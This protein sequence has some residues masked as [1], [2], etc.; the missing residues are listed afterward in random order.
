MPPKKNCDDYNQYYTD[1]FDND[2]NLITSRCFKGNE[3]YP[4]MKKYNINNFLNYKSKEYYYWINNNFKE[5]AFPPEDYDSS[6]YNPEKAFDDICGKDV[7]YSLKPQQ[8]FAA[9][10]LNTNVNNNGMLIYHGLGSGKTQTSIIIGEAFKFRDIEG[11]IIHG[12]TEQRVLIVVP[13]A[14]E[15]Q[16]YAEI[17]G[18][19]ENDEIKSAPGEVVIHGNRQYY[20]SKIFRE[21][22]LNK[23]TEIIKLEELLFNETDTIKKGIIKNNIKIVSNQ[24]ENLKETEN[25]KIIRSYNIMSHDTF[26]NRL[27]KIEDKQFIEQEGISWLKIPNG[28][29]IIDEIQN[30]ISA[31]GSSYRKLLYALKYHA[32][33][34]FRVV[35]LTGTP[36]YD[37]PYEFGSL[38]N[39][40]RPRV[41]F[42][43]GPKK[44][45]KIFL[46][47]NNRLINIDSFKKMCS[48]YVS[49]FKGGNPITYPYKKTV[50]MNHSMEEYQ[51]NVYKMAL[52][53]EVKKDMESIVKDT[54]FYTKFRE[55]SEEL[56]SGI[57]NNSNQFSNIVFPETPVVKKGEK[58]LEQNVAELY[59]ILENIYKRTI[60]NKEN[61]IIIEVRKYSSKFAK[62]AEM[63]IES[64]N[65]GEGGI[66]IFSNYVFYGVNP[67]ATIMKLL[68]YKPFPEKGKRG[69]YFVWN[70]EANEKNPKLVE[71]AK[72]A[73]NH[74]DNINGDLLKIMFG[75]RTVMEG[76]DFKNVNQIHILEPWWNDSRL[77]QV[78]ARGI[79]LCSHKDLSSEKR[80]VNVFIHLSTFGSSNK[81]FKL[82]IN[83]KQK[84]GTTLLRNVNSELKVENPD[85]PNSGKW[86]LSIAY[87]HA[88]YKQESLTELLSTNKKF[89]ASDIVPGS[90]K[91]IG[92]D[93]LHQAFGS[94]KDL[95]SISVQEYMFS[96]ATKKLDINRQ[97]EKV[98]KE[99][100]IDCNINK[101]GNVIRLNEFYEPYLP[102]K[103]VW[104][105]HYENYSTGEKYERIGVKSLYNERLQYNLLTLEDILN[106]TAKNFKEYKFKNML[107]DKIENFNKNLILSENINCSDLD[108]SFKFPKEIV[109]LTINKELIVYL[110][111]M[112]KEKILDFLYN[113]AINNETVKDKSLRTKIY[114]FLNKSVV[115][116]RDAAIQ[117]IVNS[118]IYG[119]E[120]TLWENFTLEELLLEVKQIQK[121]KRN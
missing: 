78:I 114:S 100:A 45:N 26:L 63:I 18:K 7:K 121:N 51:Y 113:V 27:F 97:F 94:H 77:Q 62:I 75:T 92:D 72:Q 118:G 119:D 34:K 96:R 41:I 117:I 84:D 112:G 79:R 98:I 53:K 85:E 48:G 14:L 37:K 43:D 87:S 3:V 31:T 38:I 5:Y 69:S 33:P 6:D 30:L 74:P 24:L 71:R 12:R 59:R 66:F 50:I 120:T 22:V 89:F 60:D 32:H 55:P 76:V 101:N 115:A 54:D 61:A 52:I 86:V 35:F 23:H 21:R 47:E 17:I 15:K 16:Y 39:L 73:F 93:D 67:L 36:I 9:R 99:V 80:I 68:E 111:N 65:R 57:F 104:K 28:L 4:E 83:E 82:K 81:L 91:R 56:N 1:I 88:L 13:K 95:D 40:L 64:T 106:N 109:D 103:D 58:V 116:K 90:I 102:I 44:F 2:G 110:Q 70:G 105:L 49:Y 29:L 10:I 107:T 108:Y 20:V 11:D 19:I 25:N 42:P 46:D 8:K